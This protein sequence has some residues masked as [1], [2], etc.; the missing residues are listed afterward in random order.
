MGGSGY[1]VVFVDHS[2]QDAVALDRGVE[3][4]YGIGIM[5]GWALPALVRAVVVKMLSELI[6]HREGVAFVVD[7]H[8]VGAFRSHTAHEPFRV[9]VRSWCL[10]RGLHRIDTLGR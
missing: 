1:A 10:R 8:P 4:Y 9:T 6:E 7:Q 2:V 3:P 5:V